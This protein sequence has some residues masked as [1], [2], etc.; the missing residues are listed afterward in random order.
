[1]RRVRRKFRKM[2]ATLDEVRGVLRGG[3]HARPPALERDRRT[4]VIESRD[5][6]AEGPIEMDHGA[7]EE[8]AKLQRARVEAADASVIRVQ[9]RVVVHVHARENMPPAHLLHH[10]RHHLVLWRV[11]PIR[12]WPHPVVVG[13]V[14]E[15]ANAQAR[16]GNVADEDR[17]RPRQRPLRVALEDDL[18]GEQPGVLVA[19]EQHRD[20]HRFG[21]LPRQMDERGPGENPVHLCRRG[22]QQARRDVGQDREHVVACPVSR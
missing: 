4:E 18:G 17:Q 10:L 11:R 20:E 12:A 19:V 16:G 6:D 9:P 7:A 1:M 5:L 3:R 22:L 8:R 15:T 21:P 14:N 2:Q 13:L